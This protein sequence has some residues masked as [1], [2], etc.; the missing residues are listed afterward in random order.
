MEGAEGLFTTEKTELA[1]KHFPGIYLYYL[2]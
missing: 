1:E 2:C